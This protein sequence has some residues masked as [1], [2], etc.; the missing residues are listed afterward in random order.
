MSSSKKEQSCVKKEQS[1]VKKDQSS[2]KKERS[3]VKKENILLFLM[4]NKEMND[5]ALELISKQYAQTTSF[6]G[7][8]SSSP[9]KHDESLATFNSMKFKEILK[10]KKVFWYLLKNSKFMNDDY[11]V[12]NERG[13]KMMQKFFDNYY[14]ITILSDL[15]KI[16]LK[17]YKSINEKSKTGFEKKIKDLDY[18]L[19]DAV[20]YIF[21]YNMLKLPEKYK[22]QNIDKIFYNFLFFNN[23][24]YENYSIE[25]TLLELSPDILPYLFCHR[26]FIKLIEETHVK[27]RQKYTKDYFISLLNKR[28]DSIKNNPNKFPVPD[29]KIDDNDKQ[30]YIQRITR[31]F[32]LIDNKSKAYKNQTA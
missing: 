25:E 18:N 8:T 20:N 12:T 27:N 15:E 2:V 9:L 24:Y 23:M 10:E 14:L 26:R 16:A 5:D 1:S 17:Y 11:K 4:K 30:M 31:I 6:V 7:L 22:Q 19:N 3:D 21:K 13:E 32:T 29:H 28:A